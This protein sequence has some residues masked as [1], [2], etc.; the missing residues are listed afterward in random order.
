MI[1]TRLA[2]ILSQKH[3]TACIA[4]ILVKNLGSQS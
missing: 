4:M 3:Y 1:L 2:C